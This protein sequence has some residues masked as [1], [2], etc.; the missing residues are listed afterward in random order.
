MANLPS[1]ITDRA[2]LAFPGEPFRPEPDTTMFDEDGFAKLAKGF[3][4]SKDRLHDKCDLSWTMK[5]GHKA[6]I[7]TDDVLSN[8]NKKR[9]SVMES[10]GQ[11]MK[12][13]RI[14]EGI[15]STK[16]GEKTFDELYGTGIATDDSDFENARMFAHCFEAIATKAVA[17]RLRENHIRE[18][19]TQDLPIEL[20]D[21]VS[22]FHQERNDDDW[23]EEQA[24][25]GAG[26][27]R[28]PRERFEERKLV[29]DKV[30]CICTH[31]GK[32]QTALEINYSLNDV[33]CKFCGKEGELKL[34][35]E[36]KNSTTRLRK[37]L[38]ESPAISERIVADCE[39][40]AE[41]ELNAGATIEI[42]RHPCYVAIT[43]SDGSEY[44][45]QAEEAAD[46][47]N[48]VPDNIS[49]TDY[50]LA[51]AQCW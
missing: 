37:S 11:D 51:R 35:S 27:A 7:F 9:I 38:T 14:R 23:E 28:P 29:E 40:R 15:I 18:R 20:L 46:L 13:R 4:L 43:M 36:K 33:A 21:A 6:W 45:F 34:L 24:M 42:N 50:I 5:D 17:P 26:S 8:L 30:K 10:K 1:W 19:D 48:E 32:K 47:L 44:F 31:C 39:A 3:S 16:D 49:E 22:K 2:I 12:R 41:A 25:R